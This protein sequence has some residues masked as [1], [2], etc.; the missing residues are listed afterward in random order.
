MMRRVGFCWLAG[1]MMI[2]S[3]VAAEEPAQVTVKGLHLCCQGCSVFLGA[4]LKDIQGMS[5]LEIDRKSRTA[6]FSVSDKDVLKRA[7]QGI[8]DVG[9]FGEVTFE[10]KPVDFPVEKIDAD[11]KQTRVTF[12]EVHLCCPSCAKAVSKAFEDNSEVLSVDC[13]V[14]KR[15][16]TLTGDDLDPA[17][18]RAS[19]HKAGFHGKLKP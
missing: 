12:M 1:L 7:L 11:K 16:V 14:T 3:P 9:M 6:N 2:A 8:A 17:K 13:D 15:T 4:G 10:G 19:L 18:L 5:D